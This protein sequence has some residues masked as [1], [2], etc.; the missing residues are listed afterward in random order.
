[1]NEE[2]YICAI[3]EI[4]DPGS[5]GFTIR[6]GEQDISGFVVHKDGQF[7]AYRNSCPHTGAPLD[8]VEHRF[9]DADEALIQCAVHDALFDIESGSCVAG[10]C[11]GQS[12]QPLVVQQHDDALYLDE[13]VSLP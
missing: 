12:L 11:P 1:M 10:P 2:N 9:L 8:W 3:N 4:A 6:R 7:F 5:R 13:S